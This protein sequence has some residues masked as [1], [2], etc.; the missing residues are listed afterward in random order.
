MTAGHDFPADKQRILFIRVFFK[1]T[2][3]KVHLF[4]IIY[5]TEFEVKLRNELTRKAIAKEYAEW[6]RAKVVFKSNIKLNI[7]NYIYYNQ[8]I[9]ENALIRPFSDLFNAFFF[10]I[11]STLSRQN[12]C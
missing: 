9:K 12:R 5:R 11:G 1:K 3:D 2:I 7:I 8:D 6:I 10:M 4:G